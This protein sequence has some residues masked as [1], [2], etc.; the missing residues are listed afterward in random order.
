[1]EDLT[2]VIELVTS[3]GLSSELAEGRNPDV[4]DKSR[5]VAGPQ[6]PPTGPDQ[7]SG[8]VKGSIQDNEFEI[9]NGYKTH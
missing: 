9:P 5:A 6:E 2:D 7:G 1:M 8:A 4:R 3:L